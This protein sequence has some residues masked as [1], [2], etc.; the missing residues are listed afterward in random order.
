M[1]RGSASEPSA[2]SR[3]CSSSVPS[4]QMQRSAAVLVSTTASQGLTPSEG[5]LRGTP[6]SSPRGRPEPTAAARTLLFPCAGRGVEH[7]LG[8]GRATPRSGGRVRATGG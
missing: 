7:R 2:S 5:V 3:R 6:R 4:S 8:G 1:G